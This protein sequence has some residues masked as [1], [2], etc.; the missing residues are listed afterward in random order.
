MEYS[1]SSPY[2]YS[3]NNETWFVAQLFEAFD[4]QCYECSA[5]LIT[6]IWIV[7]ALFS[8]FS[9]CKLKSRIIWIPCCLCAPFEL[10]ARN[11]LNLPTFDKNVMTYGA[12][13]NPIF[14]NSPVIS[15]DKMACAWLC[16]IG[17]CNFCH[18]SSWI[19]RFCDMTRTALNIGPEM[20]YGHR[21]SKNVQHFFILLVSGGWS[22]SHPG[23]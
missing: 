20:M 9:L 1:L 23:L 4:S 21:S 17:G 10:L 5:L 13:P 14:C 22:F 7:Y 16:K 15:I 18:G 12:V 6:H 2:Y 11:S 8:L 3:G 19:I